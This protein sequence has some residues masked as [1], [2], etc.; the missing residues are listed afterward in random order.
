MRFSSFTTKSS[1]TCHSTSCHAPPRFSIGRAS[2]RSEFNPSYENRSLSES[3]H[4]LIASFSRGRT[5]ITRFCLTCTVKF[6][7]RP[8]CGL[9]E[10]LRVSSQVRA[11]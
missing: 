6:E 3:Q 5:R 10:G 1:A 8:Q 7:P 2:R 9:T 4:S 11:V